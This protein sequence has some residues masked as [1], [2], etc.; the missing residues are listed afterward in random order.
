MQILKDELLPKISC[1]KIPLINDAFRML[2]KEMFQFMGEHKG[3]GLAAPQVGI[4]ERFFIINDKGRKFVCVDPKIVAIGT[5]TIVANEG[6]LSFP[7]ELVS[8]RRPIDIKVEFTTELGNRRSAR[9]HDWTARV[10]LHEYDHLEGITM[11]QKREPSNGK[12]TNI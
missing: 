5:D 10:F 4:M 1:T 11:H 8:V 7:G 6:C 2:I 3:V 12:D 9:F